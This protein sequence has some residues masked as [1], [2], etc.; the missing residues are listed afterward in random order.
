MPKFLF[1][2]HLIK[3]TRIISNRT[4]LYR[5]LHLCSKLIFFFLEILVED[6]VPVTEQI[7][8]EINKTS[9]HI[10]VNNNKCTESIVHEQDT[11]NLVDSMEIL[12]EH[13][14]S[15]L[16]NDESSV[17]ANAVENGRSLAFTGKFFF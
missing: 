6:P 2:L 4:R 13:G 12:K 16:P 8:T 9:V 1:L 7:Q 11:L 3:F 5:F 15:F 10:N 14:I 17:V